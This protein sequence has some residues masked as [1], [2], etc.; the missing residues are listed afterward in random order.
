M[1]SPRV[2][3]V[4]P[5]SP[6]AL[7]GVQVGDEVL[8]HFV[9]A[10]GGEGDQERCEAVLARLTER[11]TL[12]RSVYRFRPVDRIPRTERGKIDYAKLEEAA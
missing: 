1:S 7:A 6:A 4:A 8:I 3:S 12:P 2:V 9:A 5:G 10:E 11:N